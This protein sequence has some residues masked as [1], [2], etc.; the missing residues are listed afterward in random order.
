MSATRLILLRHG[1]TAWNADGRF[2]GQADIS[3][4]DLGRQQAIGAAAALASTPIDHVWA[5]DLERAY[6][7]ARA[8]AAEHGLPVQTDVRFREIHVGTWE[9]L[10]AADIAERDP[11]S[12]A[13]YARGEDVRR[14]ATGENSVEVAARV[15]EGL[16]SVVERANGTVLVGIHGMAARLGMCEFLGFPY[17]TWHTFTGLNNC[18]WIDLDVDGLGRWRLRGYNIGVLGGTDGERQVNPLER[19]AMNGR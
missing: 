1:R 3:L 5:S 14:S 10:T 7:T 15:G 4:D 8:V 18:H 11:E 9:G 17:E 2:Q 12:A 16:R 6:E 19:A 13:A